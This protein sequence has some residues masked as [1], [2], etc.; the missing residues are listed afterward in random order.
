MDISLS[1]KEYLCPPAR[2]PRER[3]GRAKP[4]SQSER[5]R[6]LLPFPSIGL[7]SYA[8][9]A[10][11]Q[12]M[13]NGRSQGYASLRSARLDATKLQREVETLSVKLLKANAELRTK[14]VYCQRLET[15]V[16]ERCA[17]IDALHS[18]I[19]RLRDQNKKLEIEA[20]HYPDMI[21]IM[22]RLDAMLVPK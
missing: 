19:D 22:P 18:R 13:F 6:P 10:S 9:G 15:L 8:Q 11:L 7:H 4:S 21:R 20:Q 12:P 16:Q 5:H 1:D 17:M 2:P 14:V 3:R